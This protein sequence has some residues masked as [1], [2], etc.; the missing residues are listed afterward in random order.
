MKAKNKDVLK[1]LKDVDND[2]LENFDE[3]A[4][5]LLEDCNND[6]HMAIKK[7]L[8]YCSGNARTEDRMR[9]QDF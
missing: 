3:A 5:I 7:C 6:P 2:C 1:K 8:A 9:S 4:T